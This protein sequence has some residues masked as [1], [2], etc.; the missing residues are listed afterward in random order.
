M[1]PPPF[2]A[3][4]A[5]VAELSNGSLVIT[6][7]YGQNRT[8]RLSCAQEPCRVFARSDDGG[9]TWSN[10]WHVPY[11]MLPAGDCESAMAHV[12]LPGHA[13]GALIFGFNMNTT[14]NDRTNYTLYTSLDG[15]ATWQWASSVYPYW[16]GYS[17]LA[18][19]APAES[20]DRQ[21]WDVEVGVAFQLS[22]NLGRHVET[23]GADLG[24]ARRT[25]TIS[26]GS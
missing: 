20:A 13:N 23:G 5:A 11:D 7:R 18:V 16:A 21:S 2:S 8:H 25:L 26:V 17:A 1:M 10:L 12:E 22:H 6:A 9:R 4:E 15:G 24:W 19:L 14:T 3:G